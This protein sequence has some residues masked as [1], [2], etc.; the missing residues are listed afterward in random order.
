MMYTY[1]ALKGGGYASLGSMAVHLSML[2]ALWICNRS[3][4]D[5]EEFVDG[6]TKPKSMMICMSCVHILAALSQALNW[7]LSFHHAVEH[8]QETLTMV[9]MWLYFICILALMSDYLN[10]TDEQ[11]YRY[12]FERPLVW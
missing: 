1:S 6:L 12:L 11:E 9:T 7:A 4:T 3:I 5:E 10:L 2:L 8:V